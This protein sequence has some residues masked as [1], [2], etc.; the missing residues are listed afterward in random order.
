[1]G[2]NK[3]VNDQTLAR[4]GGAGTAVHATLATSGVYRKLA[5]TVKGNAGT[6]AVTISLH[7]L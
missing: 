2:P 5:Q 1:M 3:V 7:F 4:C 6:A